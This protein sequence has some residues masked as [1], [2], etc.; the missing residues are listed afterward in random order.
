MLDLKSGN[1]LHEWR[2][3][4]CI[5]Q[6]EQLDKPRFNKGQCVHIADEQ[7]DYTI[8]LLMQTMIEIC[9]ILFIHCFL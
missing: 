5:L 8:P 7:I 9:F 2:D 1:D 3:G 4:P 6:R